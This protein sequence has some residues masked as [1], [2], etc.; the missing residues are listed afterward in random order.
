MRQRD[1][2]LNIRTSKAEMKMIR[3]LAELDGI[4][5]SDVVRLAIRREFNKR[6][7][8]TRAA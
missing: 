5:D 7:K 6:I 4:S 1:Q 8:Q 2:N 3:E